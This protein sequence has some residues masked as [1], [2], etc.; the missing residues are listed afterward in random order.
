MPSL[1]FVVLGAGTAAFS[2]SLALSRDGHR[3]TLVERDDVVVGEPLA[4]FSWKRSAIPHFLQPYSF[5]PRG[6]KEMRAAFPD[7]F[8]P[9]HA[10]LILAGSVPTLVVHD[11]RLHAWGC[12][13]QR[14]VDEPVCRDLI[15]A[16]LHSSKGDKLQAGELA[17]KGET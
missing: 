4:A 1:S 6:R 2:A 13:R 15:S 7:V 10:R 12:K 14:T 11:L 5:I 3:V 8:R 9:T 16:R 17:A